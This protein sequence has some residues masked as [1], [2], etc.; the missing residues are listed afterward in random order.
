[1]RLPRDLQPLGAFA[2]GGW[3]GRAFS[4]VTD[5]PGFAED[6]LQV[7]RPDERERWGRLGLA[8]AKRFTTKKMV[9]DYIRI[10]GDAIVAKSR[11]PA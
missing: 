1:M 6:V 3:R 10:Y 9:A 4:E 5:E 2:R 11:T 7:A 8:N